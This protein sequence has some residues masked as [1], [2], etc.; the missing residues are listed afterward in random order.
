MKKGFKIDPRYL[1][2]AKQKS[3]K[4]KVRILAALHLL[5]KEGLS[6]AIFEM[7]GNKSKTELS[8]PIVQTKEE[9]LKDGSKSGAFYCRLNI[10]I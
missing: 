7:W 9:A 10:R 2:F 4:E 8:I 6:P 3:Y 5:N 1:E